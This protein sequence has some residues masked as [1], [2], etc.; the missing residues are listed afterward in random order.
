MQRAGC[1]TRMRWAGSQGGVQGSSGPLRLWGAPRLSMRRECL[2]RW[3][4]RSSLE[5]RV[6]QL[7]A[8]QPC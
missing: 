6:W 8:A 1:G 3:L 5:H 2:G 7:L 4:V